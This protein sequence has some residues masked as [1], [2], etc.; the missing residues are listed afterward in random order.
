[1][2]DIIEKMK[3]FA[4]WL[5]RLQFDPHSRVSIDLFAGGLVWSD[6]RPDLEAVVEAGFSLACLRPL[7]R[8]R[9]LLIL[10]R[11]EERFRQYWDEGQRLFPHWPGFLAERRETKW[12]ETYE[13][14]NEKGIRSFEEADEI[15]ERRKRSLNGSARPAKIGEQTN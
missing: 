3:I 14:L 13:T 11:P 2:N 9:T 1:M 12:A 6:E 10:G 7:L 4:P 5:D 8:Y 15:F